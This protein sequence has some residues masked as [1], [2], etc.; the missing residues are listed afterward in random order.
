L[1]LADLKA[2]GINAAS[3]TYDSLDVLQRFSQAYGIVY[4]MLSDQGSKVI[5]AFGILNTNIP[6][7]HPMLYGIPFP[8]DYLIAP[9]GT[10]IDKLF[11]PNYEHRPSASQVALR[12]G[13]TGGVNSVHLKTDVLN[14]TISLS[15]ER[16]FPGQELGVSLDVHLEPG[17][18]I[19]GEPLP[20]NYQPAALEFESPLVAEYSM[21]LPAAKPLL[22]KALGETL[23]VYEGEMQARGKLG[24]KWSPPIPAKWLEPLG[25]PIQPGLHYL[26]GWFRFQACSDLVCE[27]PRSLKF[28]LPLTIEAGIP[29]PPKKSS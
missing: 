10:V 3:I 9:D 15:T 20:E 8:G 24:I 26:E 29:A 13:A 17:W 22:L 27:P 23:P 11:L 18:H 21:E 12:H 19:Y 7:D 1:S 16:C 25:P 4:P 6:E 28:Q 14:A 2:Q 5:R